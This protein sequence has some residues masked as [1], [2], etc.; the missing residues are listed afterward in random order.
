MTNFIQMEMLSGKLRKVQT[1]I[2]NDGMISKRIFAKPQDVV[3]FDI[4][5]V[6][7]AIKKLVFCCE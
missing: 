7:P 2:Y 5:W 4:I 3:P 6:K 1:L